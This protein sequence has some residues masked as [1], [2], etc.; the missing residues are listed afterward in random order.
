MGMTRGKR[1]PS[2][3]GWKMCTGSETHAHTISIVVTLDRE[4]D[5]GKK[6]GAQHHQYGG[7]NDKGCEGHK[8][9]EPP[10][11]ISTKYSTGHVN[12]AKRKRSGSL[13]QCRDVIEQSI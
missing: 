1:A 11:P 9:N 12:K 2:V 5:R 8:E 6:K 13:H 7:I 10:P 4:C 3:P